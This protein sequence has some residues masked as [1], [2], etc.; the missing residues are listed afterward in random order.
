MNNFKIKKDRQ[1]LMQRM[2]D[3]SQLAGAKTY[4]LTQGRAKGVQAVDIKTGTGLE[5]TVL[6]DRALDIA[7][8]GYRG[9]PLSYISKT[10]IVSPV[11]YEPVGLNW[12]RSFFAGLLTTCGL[13]NVGGPCD[14]ADPIL[15]SQHHG[16]HG[17]ISNIPAS[18]VAVSEKWQ[19]NEFQI[20]VT[21]RTAQAM[22]FAENLILE[23][24]I[25]TAL[26]S[27]KIL[28]HDT[29]ENAGFSPQPVMIL[30]HIN[31]GYPL[32]DETSRFLCSSKTITPGNDL[33][34]IHLG[35]YSTFTPPDPHFREHLF[36]HQPNADADG[37]ASAAL[38]NDELELGLY[39]KFNVN[40][41]GHLV[42]WKMLGQSEY[43]LG[44]EPAN[45]LPLSRREQEKR[46]GLE[47][48]DPGRGKHIDLEIGLLPDKSAI[49][50]FHSP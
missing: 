23:R 3:I 22:F 19:E 41:L 48:L 32:L 25:S 39:I 17:R 33:S 30:Y 10:S 29:I 40:Q 1:F 28:I 15:G 24:T 44:I 6:P 37:F 2:G 16:L 35:E 31:L 14:A 21:G 38:I 8:A 26:G 11:Y 47:Y 45:C 36:F 49:A 5:F 12:L 27:N 4:E 20:S 34:K 50:D 42:Q 9:V 7:W 13:S 18:N 43:V 46:G